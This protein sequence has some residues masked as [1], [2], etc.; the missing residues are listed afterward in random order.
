MSVKVALQNSLFTTFF[1]ENNNSLFGKRASHNFEMSFFPHFV[2][3]LNLFQFDRDVNL[4]ISFDFVHVRFSI[5]FFR[6]M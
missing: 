4:I 5:I 6:L 3:M 1:F 2:N